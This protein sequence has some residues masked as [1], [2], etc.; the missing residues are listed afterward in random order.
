MRHPVVKPRLFK[1]HKTFRGNADAA[2]LMITEFEACGIG[3]LDAT[4]LISSNISQFCNIKCN[5]AS[6]TYENIIA[7]Y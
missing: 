4:R 7:H 3:A 2:N 5:S 1:E 6:A